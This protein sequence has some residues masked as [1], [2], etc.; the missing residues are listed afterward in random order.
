MKY[1]SLII[2][3][4][5]SASTVSRTLDTL[6][7]T[8][9]DRLQ[10]IIVVDSSD[11]GKTDLLL[12]K[13]AG[14]IQLVRLDKK[15]MPAVGR[16]IG[17]QKASGQT[18]AFLDS[19]AFSS[20]DWLENIAL[21]RAAGSR[22][23]GGAI[24]VPDFQKNN[25]LSL[26]QYF[27]QFNEFTDAGQTRQKMFV[28]SCNLF[29]EKTLFHE[30][31]GFPEIRASEDVLFG[32]AAGS[33]S[34]VMFHPDIRVY[35]IFRDQWRSYL[36]NQL[37]LGRYILIYRRQHFGGFLYKTWVAVPLL[38][39]I[40]LGKFFGIAS[41]VLRGKRDY[42]LPFLSSCPLLLLGLLYWTAGFFQGCFEKKSPPAG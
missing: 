28:P 8:P 42:I 26:A 23:G 40:F 32:L 33:V 7:K 6:I 41:R 14:A 27:L 25:R 13:Y 38:P 1:I 29:C 21:A 20:E 35:H 30:V 18:L 34:K 31:G 10:E 15:T 24:L 17:A 37:L 19:D 22:V 3:S 2:P 5:N 12:K 36:N 16:N 4:Y 39:L 9:S 11:D